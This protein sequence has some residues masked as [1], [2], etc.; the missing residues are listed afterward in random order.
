MGCRYQR[1]RFSSSRVASLKEHAGLTTSCSG[2]SRPRSRT[3]TNESTILSRDVKF[4]Q[5]SVTRVTPGENSR[6][7]M[8][9][10]CGVRVNCFSR[11]PR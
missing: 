9:M 1:V 5:P 3:S 8:R 10:R 7:D 4:G 2:F 6:T 11:R